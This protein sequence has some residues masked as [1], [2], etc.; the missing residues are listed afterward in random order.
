MNTARMPAARGRS[1]PLSRPEM[2]ASGAGISTAS[3]GPSPCTSVI[4]RAFHARPRWVWSAAFGVPVEP[5]VNST[6]AT[7]RGRA[8]GSCTGGRRSRRSRSSSG[9]SA[10]ISRG[11][12]VASARSTSAA[13]REVVDGRG[14]GADAPAGE[15]EESRRLRE[16]GSCHATT[17]PRPTPCARSAPAS[18]ATRRAGRVAGTPT[19]ARRA[20]ARPTGRPAGGSRRRAG[21]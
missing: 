12:S 18:A 9:P 21:G 13:T 5:D 17:S 11:L 15:V 1:T 3:S 2:W 16:F 20:S 10:T 8:A 4:S 6:T 14:G 19:A 7:S